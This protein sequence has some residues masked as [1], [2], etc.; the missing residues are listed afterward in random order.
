MA[1]ESSQIVRTSPLVCA[2]GSHSGENC[3]RWLR[4][5]SIELGDIPR[6][7]LFG[8]LCRPLRTHQTC[9]RFSPD[10]Q[11]PSDRAGLGRPDLCPE[12][13]KRRDEEATEALS[14]TVKRMCSIMISLQKRALL[15]PWRWIVFSRKIA[16]ISINSLSPLNEIGLCV[17][18][19]TIQR[20]PLHTDLRLGPE[21]QTGEQWI[22]MRA[23][24]T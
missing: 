1:D 24:E 15:V 6:L 5:R 10:P 2:N 11:V 19:P 12:S 9:Q 18:V 20:E 13:A 17:H 16:D 14:E 7:E 23:R 21:L 8:R 3:L 4:Q 22:G